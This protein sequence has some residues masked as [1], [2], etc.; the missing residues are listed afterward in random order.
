MAEARPQTAKLV[1]AVTAIMVVP[2]VIAGVLG[3]L[4]LAVVVGML[5]IFSGLLGMSFAVSKRDLSNRR[6]VA[7][8][9]PKARLVERNEP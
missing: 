6:L 1:A 4:G 8:R 7:P 3:S 9:L 2:P 5:S